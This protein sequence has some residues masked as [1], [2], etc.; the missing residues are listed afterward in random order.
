MYKD[1][2]LVKLLKL[3]DDWKV[4][5]VEIDE[6][7]N[8]V[9]ITIVPAKNAEKPIL[10]R[11]F[12]R[13]IS[14]APEMVTLRHLPIVGMR[15]YL[16]VPK[17]GSVGISKVWAHAGARITL[18]MEK[19]IVNALRSCHSM[20]AITELVGLPLAEI[21]EV[22][23]RTGTVIEQHEANIDLPAEQPEA[24]ISSPS[25]R[26]AIAK[27]SV[28][29]I[30]QPAKQVASADRTV[31]NAPPET[32]PGWRSFVDGNIPI[33]SSDIGLK[34]LLQHVRQEVSA[35]PTELTWLANIKQLR[36]YLTN[37]PGRHDLE[38]RMILHGQQEA[39]Q[40]ASVIGD[41]KKKSDLPASDAPCWYKLI[42]GQL[43]IHT[44]NVGLQMMIEQVRLSVGRNPS[45]DS[46]AAGAKLLYRFFLKRQSFLQS[47]TAQL[48]ET[49]TT[50]KVSVATPAKADGSDSISAEKTPILATVT[51][52]FFTPVPVPA[53]NNPAWA[54]LISG[55]LRLN[56]QNVGL[57]MMIEQ[58]R[59]SVQRNPSDASKLA[60]VKLLRQ[61]FLKRQRLLTTELE[62]LVGK[63][64][65][66]EALIFDATPLV[67]QVATVP[68]ESHPGW[69]KLLNGDLEIETDAVALQMMMERIRISI[70]NNPSNASKI[71][72]T[73]IL[74]Q[75]F[76]K[77]QRK[78]QAEL[79][80]LMA[81]A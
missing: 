13:T 11:L 14:D 1:E 78:H 39:K 28:P 7:S 47:E 41:V 58:I 42:K 40:P 70:E 49:P 19:W 9:D 74:R 57:Q 71:A 15:T 77:Y 29:Q 64:S 3:S 2:L 17:L 52:D 46:Y 4:E 80:Q 18:E 33:K 27:Q 24:A 34:M 45:E 48:V 65:F 44:N 6:P 54:D 30:K 26:P 38:I 50:S 20:Q 5:L 31:I 60:G 32:H 66:E 10:K 72:G 75:Y 76:L 21:R 59:I 62:Q 79:I 16:H 55:T 81:A 73:K 37:K 8:R 51:K 69:Q 56:T 43:Q 36:S 23:E 12:S 25:T 63:Q 53:D 67:Q 35:D 22:S 61:F 68:P